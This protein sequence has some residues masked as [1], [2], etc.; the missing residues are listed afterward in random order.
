MRS[1]LRRALILVATLPLCAAIGVGLGHLLHRRA[2]PVPA[3]IVSAHDAIPP[4]VVATP[5]HGAQDDPPDD[6]GAPDAATLAAREAEMQAYREEEAKAARAT[7]LLSVAQ[8]HPERAIEGLVSID[9]PWAHAWAGFFEI[10]TADAHPDARE[11]RLRG[12]GRIDRASDEVDVHDITPLSPPALDP[13]NL[14]KTT[15]ARAAW[16]VTIEDAL[17][18]VRFVGERTTNS[19]D[20]PCW[21]AR[22]WPETWAK[23][24][25]AYHG[26]SRDSYLPSCDPPLDSAWMHRG[27]RQPE[28]FLG[29]RTGHCGTIGFAYRRSMYIAPFQAWYTPRE[30]LDHHDDM[31]AWRWSAHADLLERLDGDV[32]A[33][34]AWLAA[35]RPPAVW[36][37]T[38]TTHLR[39]RGLTAH[40]ARRVVDTTVWTIET[41]SI[42][43]AL[44]CW[45]ASDGP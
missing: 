22:K 40:E 32:K 2:H 20:V 3:D 6:T 45:Y 24:F 8:R 43:D 44:T 33:R 13:S 27:D 1:Q 23:V 29:E 21:I 15:A 31:L 38:L 16:N 14:A 42:E 28:R 37:Q 26:T 30:V 35:Y 17:Y 18:G 7:A 39:A 19:R 36:R 25:D 9:L 41:G 5:I 34:D 11:R 12:A 10:A 4:T